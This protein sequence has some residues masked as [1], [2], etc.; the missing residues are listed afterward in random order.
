MSPPDALR[1][2]RQIADA[3][4]A[5][6]EKGIIHRDLKPGNVMVNADGHIKVLDFGLG[7]S[8][9]DGR[10]ASGESAPSNSPTITIGSTQAGIILGTAGYMSPEQ[11]KGRAADRRSD[12]WSFGCV[13]FELLAG[14]RA[15]EGEDITDTIAA[16]VRG[17]PN[18]K[19]LPATT[20]PA[21]RML[22]E[23]CLT[24]DRTERLADMSVVRYILNE[25]TVLASG[26]SRSPAAATAAVAAPARASRIWMAATALL[27]VATAAL[28]ILYGNRPAPAVTPGSLARY[29]VVL[30]DGDEVANTNMAPLA[31]APNGSAMAFAGERAGKIQLFL[32]DFSSGQ[33]T[34]LDGTDGARSPFFSPD[35]RWIGF[36][37]RGKVK[38][39]TVGGTALQDVADSGDARGGSW[40]VDDTIYYAPTNTSGLWKVPASGGTPTQLT[41][42]DP[43]ASE[44]SHRN[45]YVLADGKALL[46]LVWTG[47]GADEHRIEYLSIADGRRQVV[48]RNADGPVA[49]AQGHLIYTGRQDTLLAA[50]WNPARPSLEGV[51]PVA[52]PLLAPMDNEGASAYAASPSGTV[53]HL[54]GDARRRLARIVWIDRSGKTEPLPV[55]ERDYVSAA[56]SPDGTR[57]ALQIRGGTEE[58]WIYDFR[59]RSFT[60]I[61]TPGGSSQAPV[62]TTDSNHLIYRGTRQGFRNIFR[63]AADGSGAEERLTTKAG[64]IQ[65]PISATPDG[66]WVIVGEG[67]A[68]VGGQDIWQVSLEGAH[69]SEPVVSTPAPETNGQVSPDGR[70]MSFDSAVT[71]RLEVWVQ[72]FGSSSGAMRQVS[73]NGGSVSR[74]S[75]DGRELFY[76]AANGVMAVTANGG[77]FGPPRLLF[78]GRFRPSANANSNYDV[79]RDG[80]F[81]HVQPVQPTRPDTRVEVVLNGLERKR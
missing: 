52:L 57:A 66:R 71:G 17:E 32:H 3:I 10:S 25:P 65:T 47:P 58:I 53:V 64:V 34:P 74:W 36:F 27:A 70:W 9:D 26:D 12:V 44:I 14:S 49:I 1:V 7:K 45:P 59:T 75:R 46:F 19:A 2:A 23:R 51:E 31:L 39:I 4:A 69:P 78:E 42:P 16:I 50:P 62:W 15:F 73:R 80:R 40:S 54:P 29:T 67:G 68:G 56:I 22:I 18:W 37:A 28:A 21:L 24:K 11:A 30:P 35:G 13:L 38:K 33:T 60:P 5:A 61:V 20:P 48:L 63:K 81:L 55:P 72:P 41:K 79:A 43:N 77:T 6:H 76:M 8:L